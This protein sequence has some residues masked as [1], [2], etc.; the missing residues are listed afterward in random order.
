MIDF[1]C[2][3]CWVVTKLEDEFAGK[4][5][6]CPDCH[7]TGIAPQSTAIVA[8]SPKPAPVAKITSALVTTTHCFGCGNELR[9]IISCQ[10]CNA[11]FCSEVCL[12]RHAGTHRQVSN[13]AAKPEKPAPAQPTIGH[14]ALG[15]GLLSL[16]FCL[17][18][19]ILAIIVGCNSI[20]KEG[21]NGAATG[22][23]V[24]GSISTIVWGV[25]YILIVGSWK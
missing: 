13:I 10:E 9:N 2:P 16:L 23:I 14:T 24:M 8:V 22:G 5:V 25:A 12:V 11:N 1:I 4:K 17:P 3:L 7:A 21:Q 18:L 20:N 6:R 15:L 19:G